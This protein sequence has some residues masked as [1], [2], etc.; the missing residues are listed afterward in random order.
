MNEA[1][2]TGA[3]RPWFVQSA[4][5]VWGPYPQARFEAFVAEGRVAADTPVAEDP[6]GPFLPAARQARL[7]G[8]FRGPGG[9]SAAPAAPEPAEPAQ[10]PTLAPSRPLL[11]WAQLRAQSPER[12]EAMLGAHGPL[13]R[14]AEALWLVR[15]RVGAAGLRNALTR[16]IAPNEVLMV[17]EA[18]LDHA[19][20]FNLDGEID[21]ALRRLWSAPEG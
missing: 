11:V 4:G 5:K 16:R 19:H 13:V 7:Y 1:A 21:R 20:W 18:P 15:A 10:G 3:A 6:G 14:V 17:I 2:S 8:L 9:P 12:F